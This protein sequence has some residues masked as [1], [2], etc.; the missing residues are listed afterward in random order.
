MDIISHNSL[1]NTKDHNTKEDLFY[2]INNSILKFNYYSYIRFHLT[3]QHQF[4]LKLGFQVTCLFLGNRLT[5]SS[6]STGPG[7][8]RSGVRCPG[9][10]AT[11]TRTT[12]ITAQPSGRV[13]WGIRLAWS[14]T[15]SSARKGR[16]RV[17]CQVLLLFKS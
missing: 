7:S 10:R 8:T 4:R 13:S 17:G 12:A 16:P 2:S 5:T 9:T 1:W 11:P 14:R 3:C 15:D 6:F